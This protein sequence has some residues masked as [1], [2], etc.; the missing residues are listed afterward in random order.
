MQ[1]MSLF[2][3]IDPPNIVSVGPAKE[4]SAQVGKDV[5]LTCEAEANPAPRYQWLQRTERQEVLI[6]GYDKNLVISDANY[7]HQGEF[8]CKAINEIRGEE[9]SV[10]SEAIRLDVSGAPRIAKK[11][12]VRFP[13][14]VRVQ[15]GEDARLE[16]EFCADPMPEQAWHLS[17]SDDDD[18]SPS[19][20]LSAGIAHGRF[21]ADTL[22]SPGRQDC[23]VA[24]L[25]INGAHADDTRSYLLRLTNSHGVQTHTV[26][27]VVRGELLLHIFYGEE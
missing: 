18:N 8:V 11:S 21:F 1:I 12:T 22:P 26:H 5:I 14:E 2:I 25:R 15:N 24:A 16:V 7:D 20:T 10:Q 27:L 6:R 9:R 3:L 13:H 17:G 19:L 23:H 4:V